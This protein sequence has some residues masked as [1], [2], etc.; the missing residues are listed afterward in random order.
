ML[1]APTHNNAALTTRT[2]RAEVIRQPRS[3]LLGSF[4]L[5]H[6]TMLQSWPVPRCFSLV[7]RGDEALR[8]LHAGFGFDPSQHQL[9]PSSFCNARLPGH[10]SFRRP[11]K[12]I[13]SLD[14]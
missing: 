7:A 14:S 6:T 2:S 1:R 12:P 5:T 10:P 13:V 8:V 9:L 3:H 11:V 4:K